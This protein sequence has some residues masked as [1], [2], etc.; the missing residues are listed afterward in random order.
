MGGE[1]S[2]RLEQ[3]LRP[4]A[5]GRAGQAVVAQ[6]GCR[7]PLAV[8]SGLRCRGRRL[9]KRALAGTARR[10]H[11]FGVKRP[12]KEAN[13]GQWASYTRERWDRTIL[14]N[15]RAEH[16]ASPPP[17]SLTGETRHVMLHGEARRRASCF[18]L[19]GDERSSR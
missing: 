14:R 18:L 8:Q 17:P 16:I 10:R 9:S 6:L 7:G 15:G 1:E 19:I 5:L 12:V 2:Q 3:D 4:E 11:W 13:G